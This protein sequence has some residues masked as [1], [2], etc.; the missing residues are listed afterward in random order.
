LKLLKAL[1]G[2]SWD[3]QMIWFVKASSQLGNNGIKKK[4]IFQC[5]SPSL[6]LSS[7]VNTTNSSEVFWKFEKLIKLNG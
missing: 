1:V 3:C 4:A 6:D 7:S 2:A 5:F